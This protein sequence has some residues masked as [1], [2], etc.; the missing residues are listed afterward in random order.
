MRRRRIDDKN[1]EI[2]IGIE[3][4][5]QNLATAAASQAHLPGQTAESPG[6]IVA[7]ELV[8]IGARH[9]DVE[10]AVMVGVEQCAR[11]AGRGI[12]QQAFPPGA[13]DGKPELRAIGSA[14]DAIDVAVIVD[15][16][17]EPR[18]RTR[19]VT[20]LQQL[21]FAARLS[22]EMPVAADLRCV[23]GYD[24]SVVDSRE[25]SRCRRRL[26]QHDSGPEELP[27]RGQRLAGCLPGGRRSLRLAAHP[28]VRERGKPGLRALAES[29][30]V[31]EQLRRSSLVRKASCCLRT[32][33]VGALEI[34]IERDRSLE[35]D[36]CTLG[37]AC[38]ESCLTE[39]V[40]RVGIVGI[41]FDHA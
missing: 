2:S 21:P 17:P 14:G 25:D 9:E 41:V 33:P 15:V 23:H 28:A 16:S 7:E 3:I 12:R 18:C 4:D 38:L 20:C 24:S 26:V 11:D 5:R 34:G 32:R 1:V 10:I 37:V 29:F 35:L 19:R 22:P 27:F 13:V 40:G 30:V 8:A 39:E 31:R 36:E 6:Q